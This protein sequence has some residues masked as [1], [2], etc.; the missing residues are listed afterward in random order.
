MSLVT[1]SCGCGT[2]IGVRSRFARGHNNRRRWTAEQIVAAIQRWTGEHHS[3]PKC[4]EW[5]PAGVPRHEFPTPTTVK[6]VFGSWDTALAEAGVLPL[7]K[8]RWTAKLIVVALQRW[9]AEH[10]SPPTC[11][12]WDRAGVSR[13][14]FPSTNTVQRVFGSWRAALLAARVVTVRE[15]GWRTV[16][17]A[18]AHWLAGLID[19][20]GCFIIRCPA[21]RRVGCSARLTVWLRDDD[22]AILRE[23]HQRLGLGSIRRQVPRSGNPSC[24]WVVQ[25]RADTQALVEVL[26]HHPL[27]T[28]KAADYAI[29]R[30]AV[31]VLSAMPRGHRDSGQLFE[32]RRQL[33]SVRKYRSSTSL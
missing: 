10:G 3:P 32:L 5:E 4:E 26:D 27:R 17:P 28:R 31:E 9:T 11:L 22:T 14:E 15:Q 12:A 7:R 25:S 8:R 23:I 16:D 24:V 18:F 21:D 29:W 20:E 19:G 6:K 30:R 33:K 13:D 1:C 2:V